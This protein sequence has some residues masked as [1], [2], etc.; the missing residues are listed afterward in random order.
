MMRMTLVV[1]WLGTQYALNFA[2]PAELNQE[3]GRC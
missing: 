1:A 3:G 2:V